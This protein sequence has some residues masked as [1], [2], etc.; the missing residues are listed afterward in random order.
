MVEPV[1]DWSDEETSREAFYAET[2]G[3]VRY[4]IRRECRGLKRVENGPIESTTI[5]L[6]ET[7]DGLELVQKGRNL[8]RICAPLSDSQ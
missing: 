8:C 2:E 5:D 6:V 7:D 4:H 3:A 1:S